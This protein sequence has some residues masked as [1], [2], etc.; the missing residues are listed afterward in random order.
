MN[1]RQ[2]L[3]VLAGC[4]VVAL[5][6]AWY[7]AA[8]S[9][10]PAAQP[11]AGSVRLGPEPGEPVADYLG[12]LPAELPA[13]GVAVA[14]LVQFTAELS[15]AAALAAVAGTTP[16]LVVVRAD[17]PRVQTALRFEQ[18]E[19]GVPA[20]VAL[21]NARNRAQQA[22]ATDAD[23]LTGRSRDV[24]AAEQAR[25]ADPDGAWVLAVVVDGDRA[26]LDALAHRSSVRAV[27]A[28]PAGTG[29]RDLALS[30]LLPGQRDRADPLPDDGPVPAA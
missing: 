27:D 2:R 12:R 5:L 9:P 26:A 16:Q 30:P 21:Q 7:A 4:V 19:P 8:Q 6:V 13:P 14:A 29:L 18:L 23:R 17:L 1:G 24:A 22:A 15:P 10:P 11:P 28:A 20:P 3:A 25:L